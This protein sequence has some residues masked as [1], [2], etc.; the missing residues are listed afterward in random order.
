MGILSKIWDFL[1]QKN[2]LLIAIVI[3][4]ILVLITILYFQHQRVVNLKDKYQTE[5][6]L[7]D[8]LIDDIHTYQNKE[9][10]WVTEKL[11]LQGNVKDLEKIKG[12]LT[13]SQKELLAK[14]KEV[15]KENSIITAA[16]IQTNVIIDSL[17]HYKTYIDTAKKAITFVDSTK[18]LKYKINVGRV[19][20]A[21]FQPDSLPT[22]TFN[23]F[24]LPNTQFVE[25]H[26][27][28]DKKKG[29]PISFSVTN[30]NDYFK[31]VNIDSYAIK[32]ITK[33][34]LNPNGWQKIG[35]FFVKNGKTVATFTVGIVTGA[36]TFWLLTK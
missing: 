35:N 6:K 9:K 3:V 34:K 13:A 17:S 19:M 8:A 24:I 33:E 7:K 20:P 11:T 31:T 18:N 15:E 10:E 29:Y 32:P 25:F 5:V 23:Q 4:I 30:T 36:T 21:Y 2:R 1:K 22:L 12:Q 26:W 14:I 27:K 28:K 16:L